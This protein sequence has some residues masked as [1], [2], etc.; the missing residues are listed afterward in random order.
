VPL[1]SGRV[2]ETVICK[3][4]TGVIRAK[5][6]GL[7]EWPLKNNLAGFYQFYL[8]FFYSLPERFYMELFYF[9]LFYFILFYF[10]S[11]GILLSIETSNK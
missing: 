8:S 10:F 6:S 5:N 2:A 4:E 1:V 7:F 3:K 11:C 9:I